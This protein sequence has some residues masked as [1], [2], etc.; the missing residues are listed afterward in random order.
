[1][2]PLHPDRREEVVL[3]AGEMDCLAL[4]SLGIHSITT[5]GSESSFPKRLSKHMRDIGIRK[6]RVLLDA[7]STGE[8]GTAL[9]VERLSEQGI[10]ATPV[11][12]PE[13][14][15]RGYDVTDSILETG[16]VAILE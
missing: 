10:E 8:R 13:G 4:M 6:V 9:R 11:Y 14:V 12:W 15:K 3:C 7:D 16:K 2:Y 5:T 1:M